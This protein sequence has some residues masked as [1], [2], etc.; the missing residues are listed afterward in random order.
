LRS[1]QHTCARERSR[2]CTGESIATARALGSEPPFHIG[3][4]HRY[5]VREPGY[6]AVLKVRGN[7]VEELGMADNSLTTDSEDAER[8]DAL[9]PLK[10][11][12]GAST[13]VPDYALQLDDQG[14]SQ[15]T[16]EMCNS[17]LRTGERTRD[18]RLLR[19]TVF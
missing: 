19:M 5:L 17:P 15:D 9:A 6:T 12:T 3:L 1:T 8:A 2:S 16:P 7:V 4:N 18:R 13:A 11:P 14:S 10:I